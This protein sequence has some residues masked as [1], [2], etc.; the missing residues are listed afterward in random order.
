M[1]I[2]FVLDC[3]IKCL[4]ISVLWVL[5]GFNPHKSAGPDGVH[6]CLIRILVSIL[7]ERIAQLLNCTLVN[8]V[9]VDSKQAVI[10]LH[11]NGDAMDTGNH[12]L[13]SLKY[14]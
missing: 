6:L 7:T 2:M 9:P 3:H 10:P 14:V 5:E 12:R 13:V 4:N 1:S 8:G 11:K